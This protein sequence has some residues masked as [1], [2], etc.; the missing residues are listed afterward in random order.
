MISGKMTAALLLYSSVFSRFAWVVIPRNYLLFIMH[1]TN[2]SAQAFQLT[3]L[4][5]YNGGIKNTIDAEIK[6]S[7]VVA[8]PAEPTTPI[9]SQKQESN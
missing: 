4:V 9:P 5:K 1:V 2:A 3:R 7:K 8:D 6:A